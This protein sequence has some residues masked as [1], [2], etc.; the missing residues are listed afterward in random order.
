MQPRIKIQICYLTFG[1]PE[2]ENTTEQFWLDWWSYLRFQ[3][4][5]YK[6]GSG[7]AGEDHFLGHRLAQIMFFSTKKK[8]SLI[9]QGFLTLFQFKISP[10]LLTHTSRL[11]ETRTCYIKEDTLKDNFV[12]IIR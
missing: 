11:R 6:N 12:F 1:D 4:F 9:K 5:L 10:G 7:L 8:Q 3:P 2:E